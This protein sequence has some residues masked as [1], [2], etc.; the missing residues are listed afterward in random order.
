MQGFSVRS[1]PYMRFAL[2]IVCVAAL[3]C[4]VVWLAKKPLPWAAI[5]PGL[6][7]MLVY[8]VVIYPTLRKR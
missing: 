8:P 7:P 6:I 2:L 1:S 5:V 3:D 4:C